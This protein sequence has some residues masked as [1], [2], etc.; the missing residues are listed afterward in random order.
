[1]KISNEKGITLI[2][3]VVTI[4]ILIILAGVSVS[5]LTGENGLLTKAVDAQKLSLV[6]NEKEAI[7][8]VYTLASMENSL[9]NSNKYF[10]GKKLNNPK[11]NN[12]QWDLIVINSSQQRYG[13]SWNYIPKN[14]NIP[15]YG[16]TKYNWLVNY[17][18]GEI[19][20]L[21]ENTFTE[22]SSASGLAVSDGLLFNIDAA[23]IGSD[24]IST[25][26]DNVSLYYYDDSIYNSYDKR[27]SAF[28]EQ[29]PYKYVTNFSGYDRQLSN[30][31]KDFIDLEKNA[32]KFN[33]NN[34]IEI[35]NDEGFDFSNGF[36][37]EFYGNLNSF[38]YSFYESKFTPLVSLW[39]GN[40]NDQCQTRFGYLYDKKKLHYSLSLE[41]PDECGSWP[42]AKY[43]HNQQYEITNFIDDNVYLT[44]VFDPSNSD[45]PTQS[46]YINGNLLDTG[47]LT[48]AYYDKFVNTAKY[49]KFIEI[50][51]CTISKQ[52]NWCYAKRSLLY[53][54]TL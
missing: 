25:W 34:Y 29:L 19:I 11:F 24:D 21:E 26:G 14:T 37:F 15:D 49:L 20:K 40:F 17:N 35:Y 8:L 45:K 10:I 13:D 42:E 18:N 31:P 47:W 39:T 5:L 7:E 43:P 23:N 52:G 2:A 4:I 51:R 36:T 27:K 50:G 28:N 48:K 44:I 33:G 38:L 6:S 46:I 53:H 1:M 22:L 3:L 9:D 32:F 16:L 12:S 30:T 54:K 41:D